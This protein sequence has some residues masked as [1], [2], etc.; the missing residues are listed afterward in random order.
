M[1][2]YKILA[3]RFGIKEIYAQNLTTLL[4]E[5]CTIPFIA[6]YRKEMHGTCDDQTIRSFAD[7]LNYLRNLDTRKSEVSKLLTEQGNLTPELEKSIQDA[8]TLTEIEDI[9]R[10]FRPKRKTRASVAIAS[11]L[12][13]LADQIL[14]QVPNTNLEE[15]AKPYV[16]AEKNV[17]D[18]EAALQGASDIIAEIVS[19]DTDARKKLR[20]IYWNYAKLKTTWNDAKDENK[21]YE[22]Y[23]DYAEHIKTMPSHR[24]LAINRGEKE[25]AINA[26]FYLDPLTTKNVYA[27]LFKKFLKGEAK[28]Y[29]EA[30]QQEMIDAENKVKKAKVEPKKLGETEIHD[31][32]VNAIRDGYDRLLAPSLER[33]LRNTMTENADEQAIKMFELNLKPLLMQPPLKDKIIMAVDPAYR[34]GCKIAVIDASGKVLDTGVVYP[35]PPQS[36]IEES[37]RILSEMIYRNNVDTI[38]IG[39]GTASKEAEIFVAGLIKKL[40]K[41]VQYAIVNEAG[42]S[43][44]SASKLGATEFPQYDVSIRSAVSIARRLQDPLAEL[45]KIDP[46]SI[47]VGQYQHDMPQKRLSEVLEGVVESSVNEVGVDLNTASVPLLARVSGL[48]QKTAGAIVKYRDSKKEFKSRTE[49]L[50]VTGLGTKAYEQCAGFLRIPNA[51]NVL[52]NTSVH[53]ESYDAVNKLLNHFNLTEQDITNHNLST[54]PQKI[55]LEGEEKVADICGVG[56]PTLN[57]IVIELQ[58]PGRDIRDSLPKPVLRSDLLSLEDLEV[59]MDLNGTVRNVI[60]FGAFV[61]IGVHQDGLVHISEICNE[62]IKHPSEVLTVGDKVRVRVIGV[63]VAKKRISLSIKKAEPED[64]PLAPQQ[65]INATK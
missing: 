23:K 36:K 35:T 26:S 49:L 63:D 48:N 38:S 57:D 62:Y 7:D 51:K 45:I 15:L 8:L 42:A 56:V 6:R 30:I 32:V 28:S 55:T 19:D 64:A 46:K 3:E 37:E 34:T 41:P 1:E 14:K 44:Y 58:K 39:N 33:E 13:P 54:L 20:E 61:D 24:I 31:F 65:G 27:A 21:T 12:Q 53:P 16:D 50:D 29:L 25:D 10:P 2:F 60:D 4:D 40:K 47:G 9:Y 59:G 17:N 22:V 5:G 52:D 11:G 18:T 43:V